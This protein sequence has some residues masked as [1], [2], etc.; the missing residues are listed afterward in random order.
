[1]SLLHR[2]PDY[3]GPLG[4]PG[5]RGSR[6]RNKIKKL[7]GPTKDTKKVGQISKAVFGAAFN[8]KAEDFS[9]YVA[10]VAEQ[11]AITSMQGAELSFYLMTDHDVCRIRL[12]SLDR[13][14]NPIRGRKCEITLDDWTG[15]IVELFK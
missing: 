9:A 4:W 8:I 15:K 11:A 13:H 2:P 1:M 12:G 7:V 10:R 5:P 6:D 3:R 14:L